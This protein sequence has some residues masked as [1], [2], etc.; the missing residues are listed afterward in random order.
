MMK[1]WIVGLLVGVL[2]FSSFAEEATVS[3]VA[4]AQTEGTKKVSI[5]YDV[6]SSALVTVSVQVQNGTETVSAVS[7]TGDVGAGVLPGVGK[8]I[9]WDMGAD[10]SGHVA[11]DVEITVTAIAEGGAAAPQMVTIPSGVNSGTNPLGDGESYDEYYP[12]TYSLT[13]EVAFKM[14]TFEVTNGRMSVP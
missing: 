6:S 1:K 12:E 4:A 9:E 11:Q 13:N 5:S 7:L 14:D 10:W 2:G 3:N 8:S